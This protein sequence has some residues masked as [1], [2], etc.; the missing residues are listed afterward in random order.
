[1]PH[2]KVIYRL[3]PNP[4]ESLA[5][6]N[7]RTQHCRI[8]N[9]ILEEHQRR[10]QAGEGR[11]TFY[12]MCKALTVWREQTDS[13]ADLNSQS[14]QVT[15]KRVARAYDAFF[16]RVTKGDTPG[17]PRFKSL[18]RFAGWGYKT[19]GD[20][21]KLLQ[22]HSVVKPGKGYIGTEYGTVRLSGV[23]NVAMRGRA[24]FTGTPK[25]AEVMRKATKWYLCVTFNVEAAQLA[26]IGGERSASFDWGAKTLLTSVSGDALNG[27]SETI[28]NP[29]WLKVKLTKLNA[30]QQRISLLKTPASAPSGKECSVLTS[31][32]RKELDHRIRHVHG[33]I[34][35]Q[36]KDFHHKLTTAMVM[37]FG[38]IVTRE[39]SVKNLAVSPTLH[40]AE[41]DT[42][43]SN[44]LVAAAGFNHDILDGAP[45]GFLEKLR[46]KA[47]EAGSKLV[48]LPTRELKP[49]HRCC[50]CGRKHER[51]QAEQI[52]TCACGNKQD[53]E[54]NS[55][56]TMLRYAYEG[57]WWDTILGAGTVPAAGGQV[58]P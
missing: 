3:Y 44:A 6:E 30:L 46:Y 27:E 20:G 42:T 18:E 51:A 58:P 12:D 2:R 1:M 36:R 26:R 14:L 43:A 40:H 29:R 45:A 24:R 11:F 49:T 23:G 10:Y 25:T 32:R 19:H 5:L 55:A 7:I 35:R 33:K 41:I 13:L 47:A 38:L 53:R 52:H 54:V 28:D 37:R 57:A 4:R 17:Y 15:A 56:R 9:D 31:A 21:W 34:A 8:Y 50:M 22:E 48:L 39:L 16:R